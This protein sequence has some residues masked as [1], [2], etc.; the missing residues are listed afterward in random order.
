MAA[1]KNELEDCLDE[2]LR[3]IAR[4]VQNWRELNDRAKMETCEHT[5]AECLLDR[6]N[7]TP[8][9]LTA[10]RFLIDYLQKNAG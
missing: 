3:S 10:A 9:R 6:T 1:K 4:R 2:A 5:L 7:G 8:A